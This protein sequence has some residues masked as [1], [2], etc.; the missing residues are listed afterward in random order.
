MPASILSG[1]IIGAG[2][3]SLPFVFEKSGLGLGF[4][5]L[6]FSS[7]IM[8]VLYLMYA[9]VAVRTPGNHRFVGYAQIYLGENSFWLTIFMTV[10][11]MLF[12]LTIYLILGVSF[13]ALING[14]SPIKSLLLFWAVGSAIIFLK[15]KKVATVE[16]LINLGILAI[17]ALIFLFGLPGADLSKL[18]DFNWHN[19][20]LPFGPILLALA[21]RSAI[22]EMKAYFQ[23]EKIPIS[24]MKKAIILGTFFPAI[25]YFL[26]VLG[27]IGLSGVV[28]E[29]AVSA[30]LGRV[31]DW[32]LAVVGALGLLSLWGSY[33][34]LGLNVK[35]ILFFDL[36]I[37]EFISGLLV[38]FLPIVLYFSGFTNFIGLVSLVGGLFLSLEGILIILIWL[39]M[40]RSVSAPPIFIKREN[41]VTI[42]VI[43]LI[44]SLVFAN[45]LTNLFF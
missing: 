20:I 37:K 43:L 14:L 3:F 29:D 42:V 25:L 13:F 40:N 24:Y 12:S 7:A 22:P 17:I 33:I 5:V 41:F 44:F 15:I 8:A 27:I 11:E 9:D 38:V 39:R 1:I 31:P 26:F 6:L 32:F 19:L 4:L 36:K 34:V 35:E 45:E 30:L 28:A 21:G 18:N 16:F 23:E 10:V 2:V